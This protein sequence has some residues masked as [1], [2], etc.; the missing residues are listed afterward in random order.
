MCDSGTPSFNQISLHSKS[1]SSPEAASPPNF[2]KNPLMK[3]KWIEAT[4]RQNWLPSKLSTI[5][6][7]HFENDS[8]LISKKGY[9]Y[10]EE[11]AIPTRNILLFKGQ[12]S[13]EKN[14]PCEKRVQETSPFSSPTS[15]ANAESKPSEEAF[16]PVDSDVTQSP[17]DSTPKR[18]K[19]RKQLKWHQCKVRKQSLKIKR[20]QC[21]NLRLKKRIASMEELLKILQDKIATRSEDD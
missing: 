11:N 13:S 14:E 12:E 15:E 2:P 19:I 8:V 6:T 16:Q 10:L 4:G 18:G 5:C 21:E 17:I 3:K 9:R 20:L 1:G 7:E